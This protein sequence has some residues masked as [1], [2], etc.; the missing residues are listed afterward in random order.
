[1]Q[2][3]KVNWF[4]ISKS[5]LF[6]SKFL[7]GHSDQFPRDKKEFFF[8]SQVSKT[9]FLY[10]T[11]FCYPNRSQKQP[12]IAQETVSYLLV[13]FKFSNCLQCF[14]TS[15]KTFF[16]SFIKASNFKTGFL[17][18]FFGKQLA[19]QFFSGRKRFKPLPHQANRSLPELNLGNGVF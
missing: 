4:F 17:V 13:L 3:R 7:Q 16:F 5:S 19:F 6:R 14:P 2:T 11:N 12:P 15:L 18:P 1:M 10:I 9:F 8:V